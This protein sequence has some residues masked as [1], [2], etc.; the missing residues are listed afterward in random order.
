MGTLGLSKRPIVPTPWGLFLNLGDLKAR[1]SPGLKECPRSP[2]QSLEGRALLRKYPWLGTKS[3][4]SN[5]KELICLKLNRF[6]THS[7][8]FSQTV[9]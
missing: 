4:N 1:D 5:N 3:K 2:G 6:F 8:I 9:K 7:I